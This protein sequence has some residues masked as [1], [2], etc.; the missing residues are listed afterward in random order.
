[1][2]DD[3]Y[4]LT[5]IIATVGIM[6]LLIL[7]VMFFGLKDPYTHHTYATISQVQCSTTSCKVEITYMYKNQPY[8]DIFWMP[9]SPQPVVRQSLPIALIPADPKKYKLMWNTKTRGLFLLAAC[10]ILLGIIIVATLIYK[11]QTTSQ[12]AIDTL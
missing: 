2:E 1:M 9:S 4:D 5:L 7:S 6:F 8:S 11:A 3:G 10:T 12:S